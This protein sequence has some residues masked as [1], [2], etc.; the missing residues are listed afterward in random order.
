MEEDAAAFE[1]DVGLGRVGGG[2]TLAVAGSARWRAR[3]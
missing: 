3:G 2:D 1:L